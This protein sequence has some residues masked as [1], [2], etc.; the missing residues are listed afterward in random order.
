MDEIRFLSKDGIWTTLSEIV[1]KPTGIRIF[2]IAEDQMRAVAAQPV[3]HGE[4][5]KIRVVSFN[6]DQPAVLVLD[7]VKITLKFE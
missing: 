3:F 6:Y 4:G 7:E 2:A 1:G 5:Q